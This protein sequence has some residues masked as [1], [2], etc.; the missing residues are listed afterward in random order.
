MGKLRRI[1]ALR[2][3]FHVEELIAQ[4]A[5][6]AFGKS[7][8]D[9]RQERVAHPGTGTMGQNVAGDRTRCLLQQPGD[10]LRSIER[11]R[12]RFRVGRGRGDFFTRRAHKSV[13]RTRADD[14]LGQAVI[15]GGPRSCRVYDGC[16]SASTLNWASRQVAPTA[17][18]EVRRV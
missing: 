8:R 15:T 10:V 3:G 17:C 11:Y 9:V 16:F 18:T 6:L 5:E 13:W 14:L 7:L 2:G 1:R 4:R 12:N